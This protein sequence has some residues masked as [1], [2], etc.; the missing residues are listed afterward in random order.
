MSININ[1][2]MSSNNQVAQNLEKNIIL[3]QKTNELCTIIYKK[4]HRPTKRA[5]HGRRRRAGQILSHPKKVVISNIIS[6]EQR[7]L[8]NNRTFIILSHDESIKTTP[9]VSQSV[10]YSEIQCYILTPL[11]NIYMTFNPFRLC[12][13]FKSF[14]KK[15]NFDHCLMILTNLSGR[16]KGF[17]GGLFSFCECSLRR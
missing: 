17:L 3:N 5:K 1:Q 14:S 6:G 7:K 8:L 16:R 10:K 4:R 15:S 9:N 13:I 11:H 12:E 2:L